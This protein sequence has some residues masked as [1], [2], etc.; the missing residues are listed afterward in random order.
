VVANES[1][2]ANYKGIEL[3][4]NASGNFLYAA[5][6]SAGTIDVFDRNFSP[7]ILAGNFVDPNLPAGYAP[8]NI[9]SINGHLFVTYAK[10]NATKTD[11]VFCAGCGFID[12]YD[13][14]GNLIR[15]FASRGALNAPWGLALAPAN[16]GTFTGDV[17][18]GNLGD[19]KINAF[20]SG[21]FLGPLLN[22]ASQPIVITKLWGLKFGNGANAGKRNELFFTAGPGNYL[23]GRFG[24][25]TFQ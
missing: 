24:K 7:A 8:F 17:L 12:T 13:F 20:K 14:N 3:A 5:N 11:A 9:A 21:V 6:F 4:S 25:I 23:H 15:R 1:F 19:G 2:G 18:I 22:S 10:Q 16:F